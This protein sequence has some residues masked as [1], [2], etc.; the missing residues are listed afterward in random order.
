MANPFAS[1]KLPFAMGMPPEDEEMMEQPLE[2]VAVEETP[3]V[4]AAELF[5]PMQVLYHDE[6]EACGSCEYFLE[7]GG[8]C[9]KV[10][11]PIS[12][13][14]WCILHSGRGGGQEAVEVPEEEAMQM[15]EMELPQG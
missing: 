4:E 13:S 7:D 2:E 14:G 12:Q 15:S 10:Q 5:N 8:D 1:K 9:A 3:E 6:N 11:G